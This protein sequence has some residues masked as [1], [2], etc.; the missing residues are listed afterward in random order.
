MS[1][2]LKEDVKNIIS[3]TS[4]GSGT[5][6]WLAA[7]APQINELLEMGLNIIGYISFAVFVIINWPKIKKSFKKDGV[8]TGKNKP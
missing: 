7:K 4:L 8:Q 6:T 5:V 1:F 2:Q 3:G